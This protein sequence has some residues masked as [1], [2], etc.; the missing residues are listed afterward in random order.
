[1]SSSS[2]GPSFTVTPRPYDV[3]I[4]NIVIMI[5]RQVVFVISLIFLFFFKTPMRSSVLSLLPK[6]APASSA[7]EEEEEGEEEEE[8]EE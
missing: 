7:K 6:G 3:S 5:Y 4:S 1:M 2:T 8:E